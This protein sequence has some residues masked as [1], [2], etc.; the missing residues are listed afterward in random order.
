MSSLVDLQQCRIISWLKYLPSLPPKPL[1]D[2]SVSQGQLY[3]LY[4]LILC[5]PVALEFEAQGPKGP[6][7]P[8][9]TNSET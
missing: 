2:A 1:Q 5:I 8:G 9:L 3:H 7:F 4:F 6:P